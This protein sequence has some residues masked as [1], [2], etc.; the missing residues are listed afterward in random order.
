MAIFRKGDEGTFEFSAGDLADGELRVLRLH[1]EEAASR[2]FRFELELVSEDANLAPAQ[3]LGK[4]GALLIGAEDVDRHVNG[5]VSRF[6]VG[7]VG[8][9]FT[10]YSVDLVPRVWTLCHRSDARIFQQ[11]SVPDIVR[12]VLDGAGIP[13]D[14]YR[15]SLQSSYEPREYCV[16]YGE[17][18]WDFVSRLLEDEGIFYFFEHSEDDHV[19][20]F[21]DGSAVHPAIPGEPRLAFRDAAGMAIGQEHVGAFHLAQAVSSDAVFLRDYTFERPKTKLDSRQRGSTRPELEIFEFPGGYDATAAGDRRAKARIE[22]RR[23][24]G[25]AGGGKSVCQR[26]TPGYRF[27]LGEHPR[28]D[29]NREYLVTEV[30]HEGYEAQALEEY[31]VAQGDEP[32]YRN[33]FRCVPSDVAFRPERSTPRPYVRGTQTAVVVGPSGE[34]IYTDQ[35]GRVKVQFH[36]DRDGKGD[37]QSSRWTR[38]SHPLAGSGWGF[39]WIPRVGQEVLVAFEDGD[40]DHPYV[41]GAVYNAGNM[42]PYELPARKTMSGVKS[43]S[44]KGGDG[45]NEIRFED[46]KGEEQIFVHAEKNLDL[47]VKHDRFQWIGADEHRIVKND[48][49][50]KVESER[51]VKIV[52]DDVGEVGQDRHRHVGGKEAVQIDGSKSLTVLGDVIES[53]DASHSEKVGSGLTIQALS[54][55]IE[56]TTGITLKA[57]SSSVVIDASGVTL[58]GPQIVLDGAMVRIASGPGS[59]ALPGTPGVAVTPMAPTEPEEADD[60]DPGQVSQ[61]KAD[62]RSSATGKYGKR[63]AP[64]YHPPPGGGGAAPAASASAAAGAAAASPPPGVPVEEGERRS[65]IE[66]ELVDD[67]GNPMPGEPYEVTLADGTT[68]AKGT[69]DERGFKRI[70]GIDPGTCRV[71]FPR[72]DKNAWRRG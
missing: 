2:L 16:Q 51:H 30:H 59:P 33:E 11:K 13:S 37:E 49:Y 43:S 22:A 54:V 26:L 6:S 28:D 70:E 67:A 50:V 40:P 20:V 58:S 18:D 29:L 42:P 53:F 3:L 46:E 12:A 68:V 72:L 56:G 63:R 8:K 35:Y 5:I 32:K 23:L 38:V 31:A 52:G 10:F 41:I 48:E 9:R 61:A 69:L 55:T 71:T 17:S 39:Q 44:S 24:Q 19:L 21:G 1:G 57:G 15:F 34:E 14:A 45:F 65:W 64:A 4:P 27:Q 25:W 7:K 47:R 62:Q 60:A 36:W 66:I